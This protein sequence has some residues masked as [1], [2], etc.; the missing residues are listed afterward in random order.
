MYICVQVNKH[1]M[2]IMR[3]IVVTSTG[4]KTKHTMCKKSNL[5][6]GKRS[7]RTSEFFCLNTIKHQKFYVNRLTL[8]VV[9]TAVQKI[10]K[11]VAKKVELIACV[12]QWLP[13]S[14]G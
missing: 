5:H 11:N 1:I 7:Y 4:N 3:L 6:N 10:C 9:I 2:L 13:R 12:C 14:T 8:V